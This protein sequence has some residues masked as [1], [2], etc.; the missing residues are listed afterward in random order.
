VAL[1]AAPVGAARGRT[2]ADE[3]DSDDETAAAA[4]A[5]ADDDDDDDGDA[6]NPDSAD[7]RAR[8]LAAGEK[9][10]E[11]AEEDEKEEER[12]EEGK[13]KGLL[14]AGGV[15]EEEEEAL[16]ASPPPP[17]H[18][19][20]VD[21]A[22]RGDAA[23]DGEAPDGMQLEVEH[24]NVATARTAPTPTAAPEA[25]EGTS[26]SPKQPEEENRAGEEE[27]KEDEKASTS[28]QPPLGEAA[29]QW[30][31]PPISASERREIF[32]K[33]GLRS[34]LQQ[35]LS[36][37]LAFPA[38][39]QAVGGG[40]DNLEANAAETLENS[41]ETASKAEEVTAAT[42]ADVGVGHQNVNEDNKEKKEEEESRQEDPTPIA[43]ADGCDEH[44]GA[45]CED[46]LQMATCEGDTSQSQAIAVQ[47]EE[48]NEGLD[49]AESTEALGKDS[50]DSKN[51]ERPSDRNIESEVSPSVESPIAV[52]ATKKEAWQ[53]EPITQEPPEHEKDPQG[54]KEPSNQTVQ[55]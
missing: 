36:Q 6:D 9:T 43:V 25:A 37:P 47:A 4:A 31:P 33:H 2:S 53:N 19:H 55:R 48:K 46:A 35:A 34:E 26:S 52:G 39:Q 24:L 11:T 27:E 50:E 16:P 15:G 23:L 49:A 5:A 17:P 10:A 12:E 13:E 32:S 7:S 38:E 42:S 45:E 41:F 22:D 30:P 20:Q 14:V 1:G 40:T 28:Q 51:G 21:G 3:G 8:L 18:Q 29:P 44:R 54:Q